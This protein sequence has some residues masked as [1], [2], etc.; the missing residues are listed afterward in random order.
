MLLKPN[1]SIMFMIMFSYGISAIL[2]DFKKGFMFKTFNVQKYFVFLGIVYSDS[3]SV[4]NIFG[5][6]TGVFAHLQL[7]EYP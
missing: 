2:C 3:V 1:F 5:V 6:T 4:L 7:C